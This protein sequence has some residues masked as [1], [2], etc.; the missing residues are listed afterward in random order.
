MENKLRIVSEKHCDKKTEERMKRITKLKGVE[1]AVALP[2]VSMC[3]HET[4]MSTAIK[5][6][7][8]IYPE[9]LP[10]VN[11]CG[12][13]ILKTDL[14]P[15][16]LT[17]EKIEKFG[18]KIKSRHS[19]SRFK[20]D[21]EKAR[22]LMEKGAELPAEEGGFIDLENVENKGNMFRNN[23]RYFNDFNKVIPN[24]FLRRFINKRPYMGIRGNHF[25]EFSYG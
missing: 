19:N 21:R 6:K 23:P 14:T 16:D 22:G 11:N 7:G 1:K 2:D 12:V 5:T 10:M 9:F 15:E 20:I 8:V 4:P 13:G 25:I 3:S 18:R 24:I 17:K